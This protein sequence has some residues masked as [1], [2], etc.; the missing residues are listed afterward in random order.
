MPPVQGNTSSNGARSQSTSET[1]AAAANGLAR[2]ITGAMF[3][4]QE[5]PLAPKEQTPPTEESE[6]NTE[7]IKT[8]EQPPVAKSPD[9]M[10]T[11]TSEAQ[12]TSVTGGEVLPTYIGPQVTPEVAKKLGLLIASPPSSTPNA[13]DAGPKKTV[14]ATIGA[15]RKAEKE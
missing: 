11:P 6:G 14:V 5:P 12:P 10:S 7:T 15:K 4:K 2:K 1:I 3:N 13:S 9:N 8:D